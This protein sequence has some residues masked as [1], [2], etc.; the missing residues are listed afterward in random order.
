MI[1]TDLVPLATRVRWEWRKQTV[2]WLSVWALVA[3][4]LYCISTRWE[5]D[6]SQRSHAL[7]QAQQEL[8]TVRSATTQVAA[9]S[10][11]TKAIQARLDNASLIELADVPL[12]ILQVVLEACQRQARGIQLDSVRI[13]E[14]DTATIVDGQVGLIRKRLSLSGVADSDIRATALV[15]LLQQSGVFASVELLG[16][17]ATSNE[18]NATRTFSIRCEQ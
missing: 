16:L 17:Q 10:L 7:F 1:G 6:Q 8:A 5:N 9:Y 4:G 13:E 12:A 11:E 18:E 2:Y 14:S 15:H 3:A